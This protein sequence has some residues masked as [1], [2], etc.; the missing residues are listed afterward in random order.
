[1]YCNFNTQSAQRN[2]V[3]KRTLLVAVKRG[4]KRKASLSLI[5]MA[6]SENDT[7]YQIMI[8]LVSPVHIRYIM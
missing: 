4:G 3:N 1:M 7:V 8:Y 2:L 6:H 5:V